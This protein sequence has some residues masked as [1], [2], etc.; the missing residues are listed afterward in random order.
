MEGPAEARCDGFLIDDGGVFYSTENETI[1]VCSPLFLEAITRNQ[2]G[3]DWGKLFR[4]VDPEGSVKYYHMRSAVLAAKQQVVIADLVN[5]GLEV[6]GHPKAKGLLMQYLRSVKVKASMLSTAKPGWINGSFVLPHESFGPEK[7]I[8][9]GNFGDHGFGMAGDWKANVGKLCSGN[10]LL[11]FA[12]STAFAA[13]MLA[14]AE[15]E[16]GGFHFRGASSMGKSTA[17]EVAASVCGSAAKYVLNWDSTK[18][19]LEEVAEAHNDCLMVIDE[20]G[21]VD[22]EIIGPTLY[23]IANGHGKSRMNQTKR[24][25][26]ALFLT[27]GEVS[28]AEHMAE[29]GREPKKGQEVRLLDISADAGAGMG[30]F[31]KLHSFD[32]PAAFANHLKAATRQHYG[33]PLKRFL[34]YLTSAHDKITTDCRLSVDG[35]IE[36]VVPPNV[37]GEVP[38]A[39]RRFGLVAVAGELATARKLTGWKPGEAIAAAEKCFG[40][41]MEHRRTFDPVAKAVDRVRT[42]ILANEAKFEIVGGDPLPNRSGYKKNGSYLID[43][44]VFQDEVCAGLKHDEIAVGLERAGLLRT[45]GKN[46]LKK[47]ERI[48]GDLVYF[49][50]VD[51]R[52]LEAA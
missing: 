44:E 30:L 3:H 42:Y 23:M 40:A 19:A 2:D 50:S 28:L 37:S 33:T 45:S 48:G 35:F 21:I 25:W 29:A 15:M 43:P 14:V 34:E 6:S 27:S 46:R 36:R 1:G 18:N 12:A 52:I 5:K 47:Q 8:Y 7:A 31:E 41:W 38:R 4:L 26:R 20:L 17:L 10:P 11:V 32:S 16:G 24:R 39:A 22:P 51:G 49:Y 9:S 13:P